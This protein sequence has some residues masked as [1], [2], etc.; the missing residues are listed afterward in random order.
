[1]F[2]YSSVDCIDPQDVCTK[3]M[4]PVLYRALDFQL[5]TFAFETCKELRAFLRWPSV[6]TV[7]GGLYIQLIDNF[8]ALVLSVS[9][10]VIAASNVLSSVSCLALMSLRTA[11]ST[12]PCLETFSVDLL[13]LLNI[14]KLLRKRESFGTDFVSHVSLRHKTW[15]FWVKIEFARVKQLCRSR[16][17]CTLK[18]SRVICSV[19]FL[20]LF[21]HH[22][23]SR[24]AS[25]QVLL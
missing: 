7:F 1:M 4:S 21:S 19:L 9:K 15:Y 25:S 12:P 23:V 8:Y 5:F 20:L 24:A 13:S 6:G 10:T 3:L 11:M 2:S 22:P 17:L 18:V 16:T 14:W